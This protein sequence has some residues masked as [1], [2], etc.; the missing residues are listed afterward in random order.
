MLKSNF[1]YNLDAHEDSPQYRYSGRCFP[2]GFATWHFL[3]IVPVHLKRNR[4]AVLNF[5]LLVSVLHHR[6]P[7]SRH[8]H[9]GRRVLYLR[10]L[11]GV[12]KVNQSGKTA[13][14]S[15]LGWQG[16]IYFAVQSTT[17]YLLVL[18]HGCLCMDNSSGLL[19]SGLA[20]SWCGMRRLTLGKQLK[21]A[22]P[23]SVMV[24]ASAWG[25]LGL[26]PT[27]LYRPQGL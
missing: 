22:G 5:D 20:V 10:W 12:H 13:L 16:G 4:S 26:P 11:L 15:P 17:P 3:L 14:M 9:L 1:S 27:G 6:K 2:L 25:P 7:V 8:L 24:V 19:T 18:L 23:S 21:S